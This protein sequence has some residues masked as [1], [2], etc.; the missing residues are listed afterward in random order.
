[1]RNLPTRTGGIWKYVAVSASVLAIGISS[2]QAQTE[3]YLA[4]A[5][6]V[7]GGV[8]SCPAI[9]ISFNTPLT[10]ASSSFSA[11]RLSFRIRFSTDL[12]NSVGDTEQELIETYPILDIPGVGLVNISLDAGGAAPVLILQF[13]TPVPEPLNVVQAG[14]S[15]IV[16]SGIGSSGTVDC[17]LNASS[18]DTG[19]DG[20]VDGFAADPLLGILDDPLGAGTE[21]DT[22]QAEIDETYARAR[23]AITAQEYSRAAQIL[24]KLV[25][26][27]PHSRSAEAQ[28]LL[29]VARERNGQ[30][31]HAQAEYEIY[32]ENYPD[33]DGA[34][35]VRQRL[36]GLLTAATAPQELR[37][38]GPGFTGASDT[39]VVVSGVRSIP[40]N[41]D[42]AFTDDQREDESEFSAS[43]SSFYYLN[44]GTS[45]FTEFDT[46][47]ESTDSDV[48]NNSLV[49][50][51][52]MSDSQTSDNHILS[53]RLAGEHDLS[54]DDMSESQFK[55]SR[56]YGDIEF[57]END[58]AIRF[59]RQTRYD[60]GVFGRFDG[61]MIT[62]PVNE[63]VTTKFTVGLPVDSSS[64]GLFTSDR[65]LFGASVEIA[66]ILP[67]LDAAA[68]V[69]HQNSGSFTDRQAVGV[70]GQFQD[71]NTSA[72]ILLDYDIYFSTLN[73]AKLS[74]TR[75]F[76]D[77]SSLTLSAD[78]TRS[79]LLSL[80]N[81]LIGQTETTLAA[82]AGIYSSDEMK[83]FALDRSATTSSASVSY[84]MPLD[85]TW[86][87]SVNGSVFHTS[88]SPASGGIP[89][90]P[91]SGLEY[92]L[93][94]Q[95][96]G[97]GVFSERDVVSLSTRYADTSSSTLVLLDGYRRFQASD[98]LR[99]NTRLKV[100]QR[101]FVST[102]GTELFAIPSVNATY[103]YDDTIDLELEV[104]S[105]IGVLETSTSTERS[106]ELFMFAGIYKQF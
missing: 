87:A 104:G 59:G 21:I 82:L 103:R 84:S 64:D 34:V 30:F 25:S 47:S 48:Y 42:A 41:N 98:E 11:D 105:R 32:L 10:F 88:A 16:L 68:Y 77:Q 37:A 74:G 60:G 33:G 62:W 22:E 20:E 56:A 44:Q 57:K 28:E 76:D 49:T 58:M 2:S 26:M 52:D 93:S 9:F 5:Q 40:R 38:A 63:T 99:V 81:S 67:G 35:R 24:T 79:P 12:N 72:F 27:P 23:A 7:G 8:D 46:N 65:L 70:E 29:G 90:V 54:F 17:S 96:V 78:Y 43:L 86:M 91:S 51:L 61:G 1:M 3:K 15:S 95:V 14:G 45:V 85:K 55:F 100:G 13:D 66:D 83:Q 4:R 101:S 75:I 97:S 6:V 19:S 102:D 39:Q 92:Y 69:V 53:W 36:A 18:S 106:S 71:N 94:A 89:A 31:A 80:N 73:S 50:S